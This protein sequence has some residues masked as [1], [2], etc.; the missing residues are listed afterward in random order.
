MSLDNNNI[1]GNIYGKLTV[2]RQAK[3]PQEISKHGIYWFCICECGNSCI[4]KHNLLVKGYTKSCGCLV[5]DKVPY[6]AVLSSVVTAR[7]RF[8]T[9]WTPSMEYL[10]RKLQPTCVI[11]GKTEE[12]NLLQYQKKLTID[13]VIPFS[14]GEKLFPG[15]A[16]ILCTFC[17]SK[18][19]NKALR[20][21]PVDWAERL[22]QK[23]W[24]FEYLWKCYQSINNIFEKV[25]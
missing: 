16:V 25:Q 23:A 9:G 18:K 6:R 7:K 12:E 22:T 20:N 3:K 19:G 5:P 8:D 14:W 24:E 15:N 2:I 21:L 11:C 10:L 1:V 13:H 17:N 4:I